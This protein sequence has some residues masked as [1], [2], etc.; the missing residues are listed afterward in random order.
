MEAVETTLA[1]LISLWYPRLQG[2]GLP[3]A[4]VRST[5]EAPKSSGASQLDNVIFFHSKE[6]PTGKTSSVSVSLS[7]PVSAP[8]LH[9]PL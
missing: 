3:F 1:N 8:E 9:P 6:V 4:Q 5:F 7:K 2:E